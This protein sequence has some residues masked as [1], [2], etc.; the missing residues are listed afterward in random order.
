MKSKLK[1][2]KS[3]TKAAK[4][5]PDLRKATDRRDITELM[6]R[7]HKPLKRLIRIMKDP[8]NEMSELRKAF[9]ENAG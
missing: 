9:D 3:K 7:D 8:E 5:R 6:L 2:K 1:T 4:K